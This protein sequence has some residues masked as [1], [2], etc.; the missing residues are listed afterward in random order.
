[1]FKRQKEI[2]L[3]VDE[4]FAEL[5]E[6][7]GEITD[8]LEFYKADRNKLMKVTTPKCPILGANIIRALGREKCEEILNIDPDFLYTNFAIEITSQDNNKHYFIQTLNHIDFK[9]GD[10]VRA[11]LKPIP[12]EKYALAYALIGKNN[13]LLWTVF[14]KGRFES[15]KMGF[16][17]LFVFL[18]VQTF[19]IAF[20]GIVFL[21]ICILT[22]DC[23]DTLDVLF[24]MILFC[25][26]FVLILGMLFISFW[27]IFSGEED[28]ISNINAEAVFKKLGFNAVKFLDLKKYSLLAFNQKNKIGFNSFDVDKHTN[29]YL[30]ESAL[31]EHNRK[32]KK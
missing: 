3:K 31:R 26:I 32:Y 23:D 13:N 1:M 9:Y 10:V 25:N 7:E 22:R 18:V 5:Y 8:Y 14:E 6:V 11:I 16:E 19:L 29:T 27:W 12:N 30:V 21:I 24:M 15:L 17:V 4:V 20:T 2:D 28:Y